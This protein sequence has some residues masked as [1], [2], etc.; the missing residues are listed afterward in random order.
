MKKPKNPKGPIIP[1]NINKDTDLRIGGAV[2][3]VFRMGPDK[4]PE[5]ELFRALLSKTYLVICSQH[6]LI[7]DLLHD[8]GRLL[9]SEIEKRLA[10]AQGAL[11]EM[12]QLMEDNPDK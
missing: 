12:T 2:G 1:S 7:L 3:N 8:G 9:P 6:D 11:R 4:L 5:N 10:A